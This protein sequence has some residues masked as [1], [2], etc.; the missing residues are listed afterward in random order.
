LIVIATLATMLVGATNPPE[1]IGESKGALEGS[2]RVTITGGVGTP[3]LP[4]ASSTLAATSL[5]P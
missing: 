2:W 1:T 5:V 3:T 4:R